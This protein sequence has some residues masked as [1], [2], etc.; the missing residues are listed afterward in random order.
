[1]N[2]KEVLSGTFE[3]SRIILR[4]EPKSIKLRF[5]VVKNILKR[6]RK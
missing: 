6:L 3:S 2:R 1:M 5:R 4:Q